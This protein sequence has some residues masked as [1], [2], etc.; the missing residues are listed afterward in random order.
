MRRYFA[1]ESVQG[2]LTNIIFIMRKAKKDPIVYHVA[3]MDM[4]ERENPLQRKICLEAHSADG[5]LSL[6]RTYSLERTGLLCRDLRRCYETF[7]VPPYD[8]P[9]CL[10]FEMCSVHYGTRQEGRWRQDVQT[11]L[12]EEMCRR[13][14]LCVLQAGVVADHQLHLRMDITTRSGLQSC[15]SVFNLHFMDVV[16]DVAT[17]TKELRGRVH[18]LLCCQS[19]EGGDS[20]L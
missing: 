18:R 7:G 16:A 8:P 20:T 9:R 3:L 10:T 14:R 5:R 6:T 19:H 1:R 17:S 12:S 11:L 15:R 4:D 13:H 2:H